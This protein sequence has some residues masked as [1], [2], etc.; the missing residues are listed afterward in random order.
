VGQRRDRMMAIAFEI[1]MIAVVQQDDIP[2]TD[3]PQAMNDGRGRLR[4]PIPGP[5][6]PHH[7]S[8][9]AAAAHHACELRATHAKRWAHP[10]RPSPNGGFDGFIAK[11]K[12]V[13]NSTWRK[14]RQIRM[15]FG[16]IPDLMT[17]RS[18]LASEL[19]KRTDMAADEKKCGA[20]LMGVEEMQ[21]AGRD[22][23]IG[24]IVKG[25][26]DRAG[27]SCKANRAAKKLRLGMHA[28]TKKKAA[29][30]NGHRARNPGRIH[31]HIFACAAAGCMKNCAQIPFPTVAPNSGSMAARK[32]PRMA[33]PE[34]KFPEWARW[35][36]L[37][38]LVAWFSIYWHAWG[39]ENFLHVCNLAVILTCMAIWGNNRLL[40]ASQAV[41]SILSDLMW[42]LDVSWNFFRGHHLFGGTEYL[43][44]AHYALWIRS[45][46]LYHFV[47]PVVAVL[48]VKQ[49][50]YD[51]KGLALQA[52][53]A[54]VAVIAGRLANPAL[55]LNFAF[56]DPIFHRQIGPVWLHLTLVWLVMV[57]VLYVPAHLI[58]KKLFV[59]TQ[60]A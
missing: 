36:S 29:T 46:S 4:V 2:A 52:G 5:F 58:L 17:P 48:A 13:R 39:L 18:D 57:V 34:A 22:T 40:V 59:R 20:N 9:V 23:R 55:N 10:A 15:R 41:S 33:I 11:G 21:Q 47:W 44:D 37:A 54:A 12:L 50:G 53:I 16:V 42:D 3:D 43:W 7:D 28:G 60:N 49:I 38:W 32:R 27:I 51:R 25:E 26:R 19:G 31:A 45:I 6:R 30:A 24:T 56:T 8:G 14:K 35:A 1:S